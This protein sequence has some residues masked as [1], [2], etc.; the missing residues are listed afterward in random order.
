[1]DFEILKEKEF[2]MQFKNFEKTQLRIFI[3]AN[4]YTLDF[5]FGGLRKILK[6]ITQSMNCDRLLI[7]DTSVQWMWNGL[8]TRDTAFFTT[9]KYDDIHVFV[10][11]EFLEGIY[12]NHVQSY[13]GCNSNAPDVRII[14]KNVCLCRCFAPQTNMSLT[15]NWLTCDI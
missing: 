13:T 12:M 5:A 14:F 3:F 8:L 11:W 10:I 15:F 4:V 7:R 9:Q 2:R 1:M 6:H